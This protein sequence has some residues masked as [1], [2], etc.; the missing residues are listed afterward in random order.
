M[1]LAIAVLLAVAALAFLLRENRR[2]RRQVAELCARTEEIADRDFER[3]DRHEHANAM[4]QEKRAREAAEAA[5]RAKSRFLAVMSHEIRTPLNG[6]LGMTDLLLDTALTPEQ[7]TYATAVKTS[8][9]TLLAL[10]EDILDFSKIEAG[11]LE[12]EAR[13]FALAPLVEGVVELLSPRAQDKGLEIASDVHERLPANVI[14]DATRLRQVLLNLAANAIKFTERG[15][16]AVVVK[17]AD[18][19]EIA[20]LVRDTGIGIPLEAQSRIFEEFEQVDGGA[21]R[22]FGG[23][24][25]GLAIAKRLVEAMGGRIRVESRPGEGACF[26]VLIPLPAACPP[27]SGDAGATVRPLELEAA[28][29]KRDVLI[30]SPAVIEAPL[31]ADQ[32]ARW[33]ASP[34]L[35]TVPAIAAQH[36]AERQWHALLVDLRVGTRAA[37][38]LVNKAGDVGRRIVLLAPIE[39]HELTRL[40]QAG[41]TGY[42]IKPVRRASLAA[43]FSPPLGMPV[44][45]RE[46]TRKQHGMAPVAPLSV[47]LAEDNEI[48]ALLVQALLKKLGHRSTVVADGAAA[49][50]AFL[51]ARRVGRPFDLVLMDLHMP[52]LDGLEATRRI[53]A[54]EAGRCRTPLVGLS[55]NGLPEDRKAGLAAGMDGFLL[56]PLDR[57]RLAAVLATIRPPEAAA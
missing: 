4:E 50:D 1:L 5:S 53:R 9:E 38:D 57:E 13:A 16:L 33:G 20:F 54:L 34:R 8:G 2:L 31:I 39:R 30:V 51:S 17:P 15:G 23:S 55:A 14:G 7:R 36:L 49:V 37:E 25:L 27:A 18:G 35:V 41:F 21:S 44:A 40:R 42:L 3:A 43:L 56:K 11:K 12:L 52:R 47:L 32:L 28:A 26:H 6:I 46:E 29:S 19:N 24:G 48:N 10:V 22:A 45:V